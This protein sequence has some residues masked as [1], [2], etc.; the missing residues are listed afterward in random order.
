MSQLWDARFATLV[1]PTVITRLELHH[2]AF[3]VQFANGLIL[4]TIFV[5]M[6]K[7]DRIHYGP[8]GFLDLRCLVLQQM[9]HML[10]PKLNRYVLDIL[11]LMNVIVHDVCDVDVVHDVRW[12]NDMYRFVP[13]A[14]SRGVVLL[15]AQLLMS[16]FSGTVG[17]HLSAEHTLIYPNT[18]ARSNVTSVVVSKHHLLTFVAYEGVFRRQDNI[19]SLH[20]NILS[21]RFRG[22]ANILSL[23]GNIL[24]LGSYRSANILSLNANI[25]STAF[26]FSDHMSLVITFEFRKISTFFTVK[27]Y[28][29]T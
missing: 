29:F 3:F 1:L 6:Y 25:L 8:Y 26:R 4:G 24:S 16:A 10:V 5:E 2:V 18:F 21:L 14:V 22:S 9:A 19:L 17:K 7:I 27:H 15:F 13:F 12:T 23:D 11:L 20:G 28:V